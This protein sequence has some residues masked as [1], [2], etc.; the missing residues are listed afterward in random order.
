MS[1]SDDLDERLRRA[2]MPDETAV[3][4]VRAA[5]L[6]SRPG[7]SPVIR[8]TLVAVAAL[9]VVVGLMVWWPQG[10]ETTGQPDFAVHVAGDIVSLQAPDG[11][12]WILGLAAPE[13]ALP[14]GTS[15]VVESEGGVR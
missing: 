1:T 6:A 14:R 2:A 3:E 13:R 12:A 15:L 11:T 9:S 7:R 5:A 8:V 10:P 4:R